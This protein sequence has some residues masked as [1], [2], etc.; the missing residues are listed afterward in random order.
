MTTCKSAFLPRG[1]I[2]EKICVLA[3]GSRETL[4]LR[5]STINLPWKRQRK[6]I[7][8]RNMNLNKPDNDWNS[9]IK[10]NLSEE[11]N[12]NSEICTIKA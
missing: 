6:S 8:T 7:P 11:P 3:S 4:N 1:R 5:V 12:E 2:L 9:R 10:K